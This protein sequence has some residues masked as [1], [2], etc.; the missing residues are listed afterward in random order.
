LFFDG[1]YATGLILLGCS[2]HLFF[3]YGRSQAPGYAA[4]FMWIAS[5]VTVAYMPFAVPVLVK[6]LSVSA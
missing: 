1:A 2:L 6:G 5:I 4:A 3:R